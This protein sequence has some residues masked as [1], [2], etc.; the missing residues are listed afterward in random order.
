MSR[1]DGYHRTDHNH[2]VDLD[3]HGRIHTCS[4]QEQH[5]TFDALQS[6]AVD[7]CSAITDDLVL[8]MYL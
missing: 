4:V 5:R 6:N 3:V 2:Y 1:L 8:A 7:S